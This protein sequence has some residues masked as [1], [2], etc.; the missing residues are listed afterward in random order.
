MD[1]ARLP[2]LYEELAHRLSQAIAAGSLRAGDRLP[3]VRQLSIQHGVSI[4]T[5]MQAYRALENRRLIEARPKSGYFVLSRPHRRPEPAPSAPPAAPHFVGVNRFVME[6]LACS[7][8]PNVAPLG[9]ATPHESLYPGE[10]VQRLMASISRRR[11]DLVARY[12]MSGGNEQLRMAIARR[13]VDFGCALDPEDVIVTNGCTEALN[14]ALRAVAK[15]GDTIAL[16]SPTYFTLLQIIESLGMRALEIPTDPRTGISLD[17]LELATRKAGAVQAVMLIPNFSNPL[18]ALMPDEAKQR[19]VSMLDERGIPL[20]EDDIYGDL[21]F[22]RSRPFVAK[23]WDASG[24]V[25]LCGSFTKSVAPGLRIGWIAPG[26]FRP[27]VELLKFITSIST[28]ELPQLAIAEFI[29]NGGYDHH[30]RKLRAAF[31]KQV[32]HMSDAVAEHFP[33]ECRVTQPAGG[34]VLWVELPPKVDSVRLFES[35]RTHGIAIA[36]G[37]MFTHTGRY[38]NFIRLNCG[39]PMTAKLELAVARLGELVRASGGGA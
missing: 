15:P 31:F 8:L 25:L 23:K 6:Y 30:L 38:R 1:Q 27:Q 29:G 4:S 34:F 17:A 21:H 22:A 14:L 35:A 36:P 19:L 20:I 32:E 18:G 5:A 28:P 33:A 2:H 3:S 13:A 39:H 7:E 26:R 16:E 24:N 11:T 9:C 12:V 10:K 37:T